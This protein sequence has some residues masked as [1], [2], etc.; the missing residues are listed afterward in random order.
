MTTKPWETEPDRVEFKYKGFDCLIQ[1]VDRKYSGHLCGYVAV[2]KDHPWFGKG[3]SDEGVDVD[4]H[5]G[6]TYSHSCQGLV[7][8][9]ND[10]D[11]QPVW[12]FGFDCA[13]YDDLRPTND[14]FSESMG[15]PAFEYDAGVRSYKTIDFVTREIKHLARQLKSAQCNPI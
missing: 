13:H 3:Y 15:L 7:C 8:H 6:L 14:L 4:V 1:R 5:G 2:K 10:E 12:W 9:K 11:E